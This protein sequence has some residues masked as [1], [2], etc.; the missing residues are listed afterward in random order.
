MSV[1]QRSTSK[2]IRFKEEENQI[3]T[4]FPLLSKNPKGLRLVLSMESF[5]LP[6]TVKAMVPKRRRP[7]LGD[8]CTVGTGA[9]TSNGRLTPSLPR[10]SPSLLLLLLLLPLHLFPV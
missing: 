7:N 1:A 10:S 8:A 5:F 4:N 3:F 2:K 9:M 6:R